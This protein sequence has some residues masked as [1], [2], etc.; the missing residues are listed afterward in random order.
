MQPKLLPMRELAGQVKYIE[1]LEKTRLLVTTSHIRGYIT[2]R[3]HLSTH[4]TIF[5]IDTVKEKW[6]FYL[7]RN[8]QEYNSI[9]ENCDL[10]LE[11]WDYEKEGMEGYVFIKVLVEDLVEVDC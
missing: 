8:E 1:A 9:R 2:Q 7:L 10:L 5:T 4:Y 6:F 11:V 3:I